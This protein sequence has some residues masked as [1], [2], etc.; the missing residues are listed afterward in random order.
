MATI[1]LAEGGPALRGAVEHHLRRA[2]HEVLTAPDGSRALAAS[3][4]RAPDLLLLDVVLPGSGSLEVCRA[5]RAAR[6]ARLRALPILLLSARAAEVDLVAGLESGADDYVAEPFG[7]RELLARVG[8]LLRRRQRAAEAAAA[9]RSAAAP[10]A[11]GDLLMEPTGRRVL[12]R[13]REVSLRPK[14]FDL[15]AFLLRHPGRVFTRAQILEGV[16]GTGYVGDV[17]TVD[18]HVRWLREK[19]ERQPGHPTLLETIRGVGYRLRPPDAPGARGGPSPAG[20]A[21]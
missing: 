7:I 13:G 14:E 3:R 12:R 10:L 2:G 4:R 21:A 6:S 19:L 9:G 1:L 11:V 18:V 16:W 17:R 20:A 15:L 8:A 5:I